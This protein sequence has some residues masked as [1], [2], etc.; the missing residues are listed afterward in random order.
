MKGRDSRE[1][2]LERHAGGFREP[3]LG[4][5]LGSSG[6][7]K[8]DRRFGCF[9]I[10]VLVLFVVFTR[11]DCGFRDRLFDKMPIVRNRA[12]IFPEGPPSLVPGHPIA[13]RILR[14][15]ILHRPSQLGVISQ[16]LWPWPLL[17][18]ASGQVRRA[19]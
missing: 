10:G 13:L 15:A 9:E 6:S 16:P 7:A 4:Q 19:S 1:D 5:W 11:E 12:R 8:V 17:L 3:Q 18:S 2:R 14:H